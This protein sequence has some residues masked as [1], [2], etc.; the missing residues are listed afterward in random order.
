MGQYQAPSYGDGTGPVSGPTVARFRIGPIPVRIE[1]PFFLVTVLLGYAGGRRSAMFLLGWTV[2]VFISVMIHELGHAV[3]GRLYD[4]RTRVSHHVL[5][6]RKVLTVRLVEIAAIL[7]VT[8][9]RASVMHA[10]RTSPGRSVAR[11]RA[12]SG[13]DARSWPGPGSGGVRSPA[14]TPH[15]RGRAR[16]HGRFSGMYQERLGLLVDDFQQ[17]LASD[18]SGFAP[19]PGSQVLKPSRIRSPETTM[20]RR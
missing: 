9:Q 6:M 1:F 13:I 18:E 4:G 20:D 15:R 11:V 14:L 17:P 19:G 3:V 8:H 5:V 12:T 10:A 16:S 2:A 7:G